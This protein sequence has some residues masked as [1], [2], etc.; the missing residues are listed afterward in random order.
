MGKSRELGS[1]VPEKIQLS[2]EKVRAAAASGLSVAEAANSF[3]MSASTFEKRLYENVSVNRAWQEGLKVAKRKPIKNIIDDENINNLRPIDKAVLSYFEIG[4]EYRTIDLIR[5]TG[6]SSTVLVAS[7]E[8][9][10]QFFFIEQE[11]RINFTYWKIIPELVPEKK[12]R[13]KIG[14]QATKREHKPL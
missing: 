11:E 8:R 3:E 14:N 5:S 1:Y 7:L 10:T 6:Y 9:L 2:V 4:Q 13:A 12:Q